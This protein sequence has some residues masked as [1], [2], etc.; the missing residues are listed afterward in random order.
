[1]WCCAAEGGLVCGEGAGETVKASR[2]F[3]FNADFR[4]PIK[5]SRGFGNLCQI[6]SGWRWKNWAFFEMANSMLLHFRLQRFGKINSIGLGVIFWQPE[7]SSNRFGLIS[8]YTGCFSVMSPNLWIEPRWNIK[9]HILPP[10]SLTCDP[11]WWKIPHSGL[12]N[13]GKLSFFTA[14]SGSD[15]KSGKRSKSGP[16]KVRI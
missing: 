3:K 15:Q 10:L 9:S 6:I 5:R 7:M 16:E 11:L 12:P 2:N 13:W 4:L 14:S 1:M 8:E